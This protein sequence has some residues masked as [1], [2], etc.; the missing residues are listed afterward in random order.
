MRLRH[1]SVV[2]R[3][4]LVT[5][6]NVGTV[7]FLVV[8]KLASPQIIENCYCES[9]INAGYTMYGTIFTV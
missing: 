8:N 2:D 7:V 9:E 4:S 1:R 6:V 5:V 3:W